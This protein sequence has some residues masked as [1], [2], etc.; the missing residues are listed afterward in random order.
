MHT[1]FI[2]FDIGGNSVKLSRRNIL[3]TLFE[4]FVD[5]FVKFSGYQARTM[6]AMIG[7]QSDQL[8]Q[9]VNSLHSLWRILQQHDAEL[10][11]PAVNTAKH[12]HGS[13]RCQGGV[14]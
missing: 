3:K 13:T 6:A 10:V 1:L 11:E 7:L 8:I 5:P 12:R 14:R 2:L 9:Y 4:H